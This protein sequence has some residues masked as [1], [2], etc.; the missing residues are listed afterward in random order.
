MSSVLKSVVFLSVIAQIDAFVS[1]HRTGHVFKSGYEAV[2]YADD[3]EPDYTNQKSWGG[4]CITGK[5]QSPVNFP[6]YPEEEGDVYVK[7]I[8]FNPVGA[9]LAVSKKTIKG[10]NFE[11]KVKNDEQYLFKFQTNALKIVGREVSGQESKE[12]F[13]NSI[14]C[15]KKSEHTVAG[16]HYAAECHAISYQSYENAKNAV[17]LGFFVEEGDPLDQYASAWATLLNATDG[18]TEESSKEVKLSLD[19][20]FLPRQTDQFYVYKGGLTTPKCNPIVTFIIYKEPVLLATDLWRKFESASGRPVD[21]NGIGN[22]RKIQASN[23]RTVYFPDAKGIKLTGRNLVNATTL[24]SQSAYEI[25]LQ[26]EE[27]ETDY[28]FQDADHGWDEDC[29]TS[30]EQSPIDFPAYPDRVYLNNFQYAE[31]KKAVN[32]YKNRVKG[33]N[34]EIVNKNEQS[35]FQFDSNALEVVGRE[36]GDQTMKTFSFVSLHCH[37]TSEHSV[38]GKFYDAECHAISIQNYETAKNAVVVGFFVE[39]DKTASE[40][41]SWKVLLDAANDAIVTPKISIQLDKSFLPQNLAKFYTYK[42]GLTTPDCTEIVTFNIYEEPLKLNPAQWKTFTELTGRE[43][44][45][46]NIGNNRLIQAGNNRKVY[47]PN[48][49]GKVII[50]EQAVFPNPPPNDCKPDSCKNGGTCIDKVNNTEC[51]CADGFSGVNCE[52]GAKGSGVIASPSL[53]IVCVTVVIAKVFQ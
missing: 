52:D 40:S 5:E 3:Q 16:K 13:F 23:G 20:T 42:G 18:A 37:K 36:A 33:F 35:L 44:D 46:N 43:V 27:K 21:L 34:F 11:M 9:N 31:E 50:S 4:D 28:V 51:E 25:Y 45:E 49:E 7:D 14:H 48:S 10:F 26:A 39:E 29:E 12:F 47:F 22:N 6:V 1:T 8:S 19:E 30:N 38:D 2:V 53:L 15:H 41:A 17:V 32:V 24:S